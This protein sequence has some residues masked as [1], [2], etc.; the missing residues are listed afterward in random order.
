MAMI[1]NQNILERQRVVGECKRI[2]VKVGTRL[3]TA[4]QSIYPQLIAGIARMRA[5]GWKVILV[6]SGAVGIGMK[7]LGL[8]KRPSKLSQIQALAAVGQNKLMTIYDRECERHGFKSAQLL[9]T[10]N[11]LRARERHLNVLNCINALLNRDILPIV[12]ENDSVSVDELKFGDND[13]LSALLATMTRSEL[14]IILT[15][16]NGLREKN[17][18]K[19]GKRV[20]LVR[21]ISDKLTEF[22]SDTDDHSFSIGGMA[23][24][25]RAAKLV[26]AAGEY[27]WIADGRD[28]SIMHK[29]MNAEDVGTLF[30]PRKRQMQSRKR[31]IKFFSRPT[32]VIVIDAGAVVAVRA[33]GRSLL[34]SGIAKIS[35]K[36]RRG[37]TVD[38][39]DENGTLVGR[40]LSNFSHE[41]CGA[42]AGLQSSEV[43]AIL[44]R[45]VDEVVVHRNNLAVV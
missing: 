23:S 32:G 10:A 33:H 24:K 12:N 19:L 17:D 29:I 39:V 30:V 15:T 44:R 43:A 13:I 28:D 45:A 5:H 6:S 18:G 34:P 36:F 20:S 27:L 38:I 22:A 25:L 1:N 26:T 16:E 31:W 11:D 42:I 9:L 35:G 41:E 2:V 21:H 14:T 4:K 7:E 8:T 37:D 40:G 3:L